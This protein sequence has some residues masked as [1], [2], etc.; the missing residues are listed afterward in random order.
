MS[1]VILPVSV[2]GILVLAA[3]TLLPIRWWCR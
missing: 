3:M 2:L 1:G